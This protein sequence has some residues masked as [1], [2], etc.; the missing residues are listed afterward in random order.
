MSKFRIQK[1]SLLGG[2]VSP[3]AF[4][5]TDLPLYQAAC[6]TLKNM[7]PMLS[8]GAYRRP[9]TQ[10]DTNMGAVTSIFGPTIIPFQR[11]QLE[12][13]VVE[14]GRTKNDTGY[15]NVYRQLSSSVASLKSAVDVDDV[16]M[17]T[18][19]TCTATAAT[20]LI[21][22]SLTELFSYR[23]VRFTTTGTL[24][25]GISLNT[26]YW[27]IYVSATTIR[28]A[29]DL[30]NAQANSFVDITST[31]SGVHTI[32]M[33]DVIPWEPATEA[34]TTFFY[35]EWRDVQ[36][37][38]SA[39]VMW[40]VHPNRK[41]RR[42][43]RI[44]TDIFYLQEFDQ[45]RNEDIRRDAWPYMAQ[46][47]TA[48]TMTNSVTA[49][50]A[51]GTLTASVAYF[52][53]NH[54]GSMFKIEAGGTIGS[55][56]VTGYTSATVVTIRVVF[57]LPASA[58]HLSWWESAWSDYRGWPRSVCFYKNRI[59][60]GGNASFPDTIWFS[61]DGNFDELSDDAA[62]TPFVSTVNSDAFAIQLLSEQTNLIQ[63]MS[64]EKALAVGTVGDEW[65]I[66]REREDPDLGFGFEN[67]EAIKQ[68]SYGSAHTIPQRIGNE[69]IFCQADEEEIRSFIFNFQEDSFVA[70]PIQTL[71]DEFPYPD[72][73]LQINGNRKI[74]SFVWDKSRNTLWCLDTKGRW[75]G[76]TRDRRLGV[77]VW[78]SQELG[79]FDDS[80]VGSII[81]DHVGNQA[82]DPVYINPTGTIL[83]LMVLPNIETRVQDIWA[84]VYRKINGVFNFYLERIVGKNNIP[85]ESAYADG[86][87]TTDI[88]A[89]TDCSFWDFNEYPG[90]EDYS[91]SG[92][93]HLEGETPVGTARGTKGWFYITGSAVSGGA[94]TL[95]TPYPGGITSELM[96]FVF[97]YHYDSIIEPLRIEAG[98]KIGSSQAAIK[99]IHELTIRFYKTLAC[100]VGRDADNLEQIIFRDAS[101]P[102]GNNPE[103]FTGDKRVYLDSE[104]DRDG[105]VYII[106]DRPLPFAVVSIIA[107]GVTFD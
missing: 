15:M 30:V 36:Y 48:T 90:A 8:G 104:H 100:K 64:P 4:G 106:Q 96:V 43:S 103:F 54:V 79:G 91:F 37:T 70:E 77:N 18:S 56:L 62:V 63:W 25:A 68:T 69:L 31:G 34:T 42:L 29:T 39:D 73:N 61:E 59:A 53:P 19:D 89:N 44:G 74:R 11:S 2:E 22:H 87:S 85:L 99:R 35:D 16:T 88:R 82:S 92:L 49:I 55:A 60:Y 7:I 5:R 72:D 83:S 71:Y 51:E 86:F 13:Y 17:D 45:H 98:S 65:L 101:L 6:K 32:T 76:L 80:V 105:L 75:R 28:I 50:G 33:V 24:P 95:Q 21:T 40:L 23:K 27:S 67:S 10:F 41:P 97:G 47:T 20:D 81:S 58:A 46:N 84:V 38:Q 3:T 26:T 107:E 78:S 1:T 12:A 66:N 102:M 93:S 57:T 94:T 52:S 9:G 14:I